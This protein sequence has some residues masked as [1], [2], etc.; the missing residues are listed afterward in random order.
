MSCPRRN[1]LLLAVAVVLTFASALNAGSQAAGSGPGPVLALRTGEVDPSTLPNLLDAADTRIAAGEHF[2]IQLDGPMTAARRA[3]LE[4]MGLTIGDY[5]P[6]NAF[7]VRGGESAPASLVSAGFVRWAGR[8]RPE[9]RLDPQMGRLTPQTPERQALAAAGKLVLSVYLFAGADVASAAADLAETGAELSA[10]DLIGDQPVLNV[11]LPASELSA[12]ANLSAVQFVEEY[13]EFTLRNNSNRWIVQSNVTNVTP[14]YD[15]GLHGEGQI[16]GHIDGRIGSNHC[17]FADPNHPIG[18][19]HRKIVAYN[20]SSGYDL[21]GTHT[22]GTAVGDGGTDSNTR[23]V[24]YLAR[25]AH[26]TIPSFSETQMFSRLTLHYSQGATVHTNSWGNDGTVA[27]DGLCRAI[28]NFSWLYDDNLVAFAVTNLSSLKNPENAKNCLAVG[29]SQDTPSQNNHCSGGVGP[30]ADGRRKPEIYAPGCGTNSSSGSTGCSTSSLTGTSMA[31]PAVVGTG[32]LVRQYFTDGYYPSG[33]AT[34]A[35]GFVPSGALIKAVLI[36]SS[37]DM[38]GISG[39]P[40]N[41][42]GWGRVLADNALYFPGDARRLIVF[43]VRNSTDA[44]LTTGENATY[45]V[46]VTESTQQLRVTLAWHDYPGAVNSGNPVVNNLDLVVQ[47]PSGTVYKGNVFSGGVSVPG[48]TSDPK[49]NLEQVHLNNPELGEWTLTISAT[50]VNNGQQGYAL[51]ATG[52]LGDPGCPS[53][54]SPPQ[55]ALACVGS[56]IELAVVAGGAAPLS[57]QWRRDGVELP[58]ANASVLGLIVTPEDGGSYD[59]VVSNDCG[60]VTSAAAVL[61][62]A[63]PPEIAQDPAGLSLRVGQTA[64]FTVAAGGSEPL[65]Y[66]WRKDGVPLV[67]GGRFSGV[68]SAELTIGPLEL[69]DSGAYDVLVGNACGAAVSAAAVLSV[70]AA[71]DMNCDGVVNFG[72]INP[73]VEALTDPGAYVQLFPG[74]NALNGDLNGDNALGFADINLFVTLLTGQ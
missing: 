45:T 58:G 56:Y 71:G 15:H 17:S 34:P 23:G 20:A 73:L 22:A 8:Y 37:V 64:V 36:N 27:Y 49:N 66:Q 28:D 53:I 16:L 47:S 46:E 69:T 12:L 62:V 60:S 25:L 35:D 33:L 40:S 13:P 43:D 7:I 4:Q 19:E 65:E 70:W 14:L 30:T 6:E 59:C 72:D 41:L 52:G 21:H 32:L 55:S 26:N 10:V 57:Y 18:P 54:L 42:E 51:V 63:N 9:W 5:L 2:V 39:Y 68:L 29:A 61:T 24:A 38:T 31:C 1:S 44:A 48:G 3:A 74:C 67:D 50:A 11:V